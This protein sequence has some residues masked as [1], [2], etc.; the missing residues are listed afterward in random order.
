MH[1]RRVSL[2][3]NQGVEHRSTCLLQRE[4]ASRA[5]HLLGSLCTALITRGIHPGPGVAWLSLYV[6][7][8]LSCNYN[9]V[10]VL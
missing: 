5:Q 9:P 8:Q 3:I 6:C 2:S 10:F 7:I 4:K 1:V